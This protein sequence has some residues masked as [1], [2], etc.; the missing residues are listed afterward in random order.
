MATRTVS[1]DTSH[2]H[3]GF[4]VRHLMISKVRGTFGTWEGTIQLDEDDLA[5]SSVEV[6]IQVASVDTKEEKRDA[7]L[8]SADFFDAEQHPTMTFK[9]RKVEVE[10]GQVARVVG[11]LTIRGTTHEVT[12]E[13]EDLGKSKDPWG[14]ERVGYAAKTR[15]NRTDYGLNW[16]QALELGGVLV[17]EKVDIELDLEGI[18]AQAKAA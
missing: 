12:L 4:S 5:K 15:I 16:N 10:G 6:T 14:N 9:S 13:V 11:D 18:V 1:I 17:G 7:H 8:R 3:V 2:S